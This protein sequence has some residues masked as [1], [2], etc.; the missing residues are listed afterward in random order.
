MPP[1]APRYD[2]P[3][4]QQQATPSPRISGEVSLSGLG[5]GDAA[6]GVARTIRGAGS[7]YFAIVQKEKQTADDTATKDALNQTVKLSN[8]L[9]YNPEHGATTK[10]GKDAFGV[11]DDYSSQYDKGADE[12]ENGLKNQD[13]KNAYKLM[14]AQYRNGLTESLQKHTRSES[15]KFENETFK[16]LLT[17]N[18]DDAVLHYNDPDRIAQALNI[19]RKAI[20]SHADSNGW[21]PAQKDQALSETMSKTHSGVIDQYLALGQ[22]GYAKKYYEDNKDDINGAY[23]TDLDK[24]LLEGSL[25]GDAQ[26]MVDKFTTD[27]KMRDASG[28]LDVNKAYEQTKKIEDIKLRD[29]TERRLE[30]ANSVQSAAIKQKQTTAYEQIGN[31]ADK[32][33]DL[34]VLHSDPSWSQLSI[35]EKNAVDGYVMDRISGKNTQTDRS[36]YRELNQLAS[37]NRKKFLDLN[38]ASPEYRYKLSESDFK[39]FD[40]MQNEAK[41]G[42]TEKIDGFE[43]DQEVVNSVIQQAGIDPKAKGKAT[44]ERYNRV[45][46]SIDVAVEKQSRALG[47][48][49]TNDEIRR[50]SKMQTVQWITDK[51]WFSDTKK[52]QGELGP[53]DKPTDLVVPDDDAQAIGAELKRRGKPVTKDNI[54]LWYIRGLKNGG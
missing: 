29:E 24:K 50:I 18:Y 7:E 5:G 45:K 16:S 47:R 27:P 21:D 17:T 39:K 46:E 32:T 30:H 48:K 35:P 25:K 43:S 22:D 23:R 34:N 14:R 10:Q 28:Y 11:I 3:E 4:I 37:S 12:I 31:L 19:Q 49:L 51:G 1:V 26:R 9:L 44:Q 40:D 42:N 54:N 53:N 33:A 15:V 52:L 20:E 6:E 41:R 38:L 2:Q 8:D 36:T 13:Q